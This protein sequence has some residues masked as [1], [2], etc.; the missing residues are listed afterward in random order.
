MNGLLLL[1]GV[2]GPLVFIPV[3]LYIGK[4]RPGYS[5]IRTFIS[6]LCLDGGARWQ[7]RTFIVSG[8]LIAVFGVALRS[9]HLNSTVPWSGSWAIVGAGLGFIGIGIHRDDPWLGYPPGPDTPEG[10][11][12]PRSPNGWAHLAFSMTTGILLGAS[13]VAFAQQWDGP[14]WFAYTAVSLVFFALFYVAAWASGSASAIPGHWAG[15]RAG[16]LQR[17]SIFTPLVWIAAF[18]GTLVLTGTK[19]G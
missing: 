11:G 17:L 10:I 5:P 15:G 12:L 18:A 7:I 19:A 1:A 13:L 16:L 3:T 4:T 6:Q 9:L 2:L 14:A 8:T